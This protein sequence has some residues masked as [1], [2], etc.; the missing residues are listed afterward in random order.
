MD[1]LEQEI[2]QKMQEIQSKKQEINTLMQN[3]MLDETRKSI[4]E[5]MYKKFQD[6]LD[7]AAAKEIINEMYPQLQKEG[8]R[9]HKGGGSSGGR[10]SGGRGDSDSSSHQG[11]DLFGDH[12]VEKQQKYPNKASDLVKDSQKGG[13]SSQTGGGSTGGRST[14][15]GQRVE[16]TTGKTLEETW[17]DQEKIVDKIGEVI[18][19][20]DNEGGEYGKHHMEP[21]VSAEPRATILDE[22]A[23]FVFL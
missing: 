13:G 12:E 6:S 7:Q 4:N 1:Q 11:F 10:L 8:S 9:G 23:A 14:Q 21:G 22:Y 16:L 20:V 2:M 3:A 18:D 15:S 17:K 19:K 5:K